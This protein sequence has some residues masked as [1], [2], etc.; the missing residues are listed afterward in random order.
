V[1]PRLVWTAEEQVHQAIES[2]GLVALGRI[3]DAFVD[4]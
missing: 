1:K 4:R 2:S 3:P